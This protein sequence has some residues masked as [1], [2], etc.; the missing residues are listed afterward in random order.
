MLVL[1]MEFSRGAQRAHRASIIKEQTDERAQCARA[2]GRQS[3][4]MGGPASR[5]RVGIAPGC[6]SSR[7]RG[8]L[9]QNGIVMPVAMSRAHRPHERDPRKDAV[10]QGRGRR[11]SE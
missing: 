1:A 3:T 9:P 5:R 7:N 6:S 8:S 2:S 11:D 10:R 4:R